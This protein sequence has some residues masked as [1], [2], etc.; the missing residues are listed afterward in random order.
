M[1]WVGR[2]KRPLS[3]TIAGELTWLFRENS[4]AFRQK[5]WTAFCATMRIDVPRSK[6]AKH[7]A[8]VGGLSDAKR[9]LKRL[10][11]K[12]AVFEAEESVN[13]E[14]AAGKDR[15]LSFQITENAKVIEICC[16]DDGINELIDVLSKLRGSGSHIHLYAPSIG[17][18]VSPLSDTTPFGEP[19]VSEVIITH[20]GD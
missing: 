9:W 17:G 12:T 15:M 10:E 13:G 19:A 6:D 18:S 5:N 4:G 7:C 1:P 3:R 11:A 14:E 2:H 16:D 20:G 8:A